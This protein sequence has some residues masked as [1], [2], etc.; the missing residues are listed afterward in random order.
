MELSD[1]AFIALV[2]KVFTHKPR[3]CKMCRELSMRDLCEFT[4]DDLYQRRTQ[5]EMNAYYQPRT[6]HKRP[7]YDHNIRLHRK[8]C[9][10]SELTEGDLRTLGIR[11]DFTSMLQLA[12][13]MR[14]DK[15]M[16]K[17]EL[18]EELY[19]QRLNNLY[20]LQQQ[21]ELSK[22]EREDL[23]AGVIP[24]RMEHTYGGMVSGSIAPDFGLLSRDVSVNIR[25]IINQIDTIQ[26]DIQRTVATANKA[27][28]S[29]TNTTIV[30]IANT[31]LMDVEAQL[32]QMLRRTKEALEE[33]IPDQPQLVHSIMQTIVD[34]IKGTVHPVIARTKETLLLEK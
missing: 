32:V 4:L 13:N 12:Y 17:T 14:F 25:S 31:S 19:R 3:E 24:K 16:S 15:S 7:I 9:A 10:P 28:K 34:S 5:A 33:R 23:D 29:V 18:A 30:Q 8:H 6:L 20:E 27:S 11:E 26:S 2:S 1:E 21:L 22:R